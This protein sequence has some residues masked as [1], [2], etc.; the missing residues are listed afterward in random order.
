LNNGFAVK[1]TSRYPNAFETDIKSFECLDALAEARMLKI[2]F[3]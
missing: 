1:M 2:G 3:K